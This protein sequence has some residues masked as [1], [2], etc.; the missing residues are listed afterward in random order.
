MSVFLAELDILRASFLKKTL[1]L[2]EVRSVF[3]SRADRLLAFFVL[4]VIINFFLSLMIPIWM[5]AVG[6]ILFGAPH[7]FAGVRYI[8]KILAKNRSSKELRPLAFWIVGVL[9]VTTCLHV[10]QDQLNMP[11]PH[12]L[13][14]A[15]DWE[16]M[17]V[18]LTFFT[19]TW[20]L[21]L[22][23]G[24][25]RNLLVLAPLA[26]LSWKYPLWTAGFFLIGHNFVAFI[27]WIRSAKIHREKRTA[28]LA[29]VIFSLLTAIIFLG[30]A[31]DLIRL[32]FP[33]PFLGISL[34]PI[35]LGQLVLP[36]SQ[37]YVLLDRAVS[38]FAF[39][40]AMHYFVWLKAIPEQVI[41]QEVP[42]SFRRSAE[43]LKNDLGKTLAKVAVVLSCS[44]ILAMAFY[45]LELIRNL[46][47]SG[48]TVH[49][50]LEFA[51][52]T[53]LFKKKA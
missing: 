36:G 16:W 45:K 8:P 13:H 25:L 33:M 32:P 21:K 15:D 40:Q 19:F 23:P 42:L 28:M 34:E 2:K 7:L 26:F 35:S 14:A 5:L 10:F 48:A 39:G 46:Y 44:F 18:V 51:G 20:F 30:C 11:I 38:V 12:P 9:F 4:A 6:P 17:T 27:Y 3:L 41:S 29:F 53:F 43:E 47:L 1:Y 50:Y 31:D 24:H 49:G 52:L 22:G 37:N